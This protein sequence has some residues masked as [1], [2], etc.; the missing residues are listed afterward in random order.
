MSKTK[1]DAYLNMV[2]ES[3][4]TDIQTLIFG[5]NDEEI[6]KMM[7]V[8]VR[9]SDESNSFKLTSRGHYILSEL[10][11][12]Y[13]CDIKDNDELKGKMLIQFDRIVNTPWKIQGKIIYFF[14]EST[15]F[16][17]ALVERFENFINLYN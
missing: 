14:D 6:L 16:N 17:F 10:L 7:F 8:A 5:M 1:Y 11:E 9:Y 15:A 2:K 13:K 3:E 12:C 4:K